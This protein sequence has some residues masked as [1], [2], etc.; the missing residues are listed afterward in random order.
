MELYDALMKE[1]RKGGK[2]LAASPSEA[3]PLHTPGPLRPRRHLARWKLYVWIFMAVVVGAGIFA[4]GL[5]YT[6]TT[7]TIEPRRLPFSLSGALITVAHTRTP[8]KDELHFQK[9][10]LDGSLTREV[11]G[12]VLRES[13]IKATGT[14]VIHNEYSS[15]P[16]ALKKGT[17]LTSEKGGKRYALD[18]AVTVPGFTTEGG[19]RRG[20]VSAPVR[21]TA[22]AV[23]P[24]Y[25]LL[26]GDF[27]IAGYTTADKKKK[28]FARSGEGV[29]GGESGL[30][31][32]LSSQEEEKI[33]TTMKS[34]LEEKLK[35]QARTQ[36]PEGFITFPE[37][38]SFSA[39]IEGRLQNQQVKFPVTM[40]GVLALYLFPEEALR[41]AVA[42]RAIETNGRREVGVR[43]VVENI[44]ALSIESASLL[45]LESAAIPES[46][47]LK[48]SGEGMLVAEVETD[49]IAGALL[50]RRVNQFE[51]ILEQY[52]SVAGA[53]VTRVPFWAPYF[54]SNVDR[55]TLKVK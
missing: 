24:E 27:S 33:K 13:F 43:Y 32:G 3:P 50:G 16:I 44:Q 25:N 40:E 26:P 29:S 45:P 28:V 42:D 10:V 49:Q 5:A 41:V 30:V 48:I 52:R 51:T 55:I 6:K 19:V 21:I 38:T 8:S 22:S 23:G 1:K 9:M 15:K 53:E 34:L 4:L 46:L 12:D 20:G 37:L 7:V 2:R 18:T 31:H 11:L 39:R 17:V 14:V 54:P 36:I 47:T 35:R